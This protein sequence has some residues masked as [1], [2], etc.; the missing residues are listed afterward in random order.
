MSNKL[1]SGLIDYVKGAYNELVNHV[2]WPSW[3]EVQK[4]T[5]VVAI[6]TLTFSIFI[7]IVD[8]LFR[9]FLSQYYKLIK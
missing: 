8:R 1:F 3:Q 2:V 6:F 5:V 7:F 4:S 9:G